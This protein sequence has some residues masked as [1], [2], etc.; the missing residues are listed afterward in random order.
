MIARMSGQVMTQQPPLRQVPIE[1][2]MRG[3]TDIAE[4]QTILHTT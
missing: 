1:P 2:P 4:L 3:W